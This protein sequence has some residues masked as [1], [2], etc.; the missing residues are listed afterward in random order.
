MTIRFYGIFD[1][2]VIKNEAAAAL[3]ALAG[4][5]SVADRVVGTS[6]WGRFGLARLSTVATTRRCAAEPRLRTGGVHEH[7]IHRWNHRG[8]NH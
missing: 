4:A 3:K 7:Q 2:N 6:V 8:A 1:R 5:D